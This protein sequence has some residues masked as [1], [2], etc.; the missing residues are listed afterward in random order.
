[1]TH[2]IADVGVWAHVMGASTDWG[3]ETGNNH[4]N[5]EEYVN[6]RTS[7]YSDTFISYLSFDGKLETISAYDAAIDLAND[8]TFDHG[9]IYTCVW[10]NNNYNISN[11]VYWNRA[12]ESLNL[13]VNYVAD[14]LHTLYISSNQ[15][16][17]AP[18]LTS[19]PT[20]T[21]SATPNPTS[22]SAST[23]TP[24][25]TPTVSMTFPQPTPSPT[26]TATPTITS[27]AI[28]YSSQPPALSPTIPE[29]PSVVAL[30]V[31]A[32]SILVLLVI[33]KK[34]MLS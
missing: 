8:S 11:P 15:P 18:S 23:S 34:R 20:L 13:A 33:A 5:Y 32:I 27:T 19:T 10:M 3:A 17:P 28:P 4:S 14:V 24:I 6:R 21:P 12:G 26:K 29:F 16:S 9:G 22:S 7:T 2:Y 31:L 30:A 1:M 25:P